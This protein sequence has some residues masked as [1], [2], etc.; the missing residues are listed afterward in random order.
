M[1]G[2]CAHAFGLFAYSVLVG[3]CVHVNEK[4]FELITSSNLYDI[5]SQVTWKGSS[6]F[7]MLCEGQYNSAHK[8]MV[9]VL[10]RL[11]YPRLEGYLGGHCD[12]SFSILI[13]K[14]SLLY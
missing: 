7:A 3:A 10:F 5:S 14:P 13:A 1:I 6:I 4:C 11:G 12:D 9:Q 2:N 8:Y